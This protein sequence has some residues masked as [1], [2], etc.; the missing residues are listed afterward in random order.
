[1]TLTVAGG[2][3]GHYSMYEDNGTD[4]SRSAT[5]SVDYREHGGDHQLSISPARG[6][7]P[8]QV[9]Q[10]QWTVQFRDADAPH[11][12]LVDGHPARWTYDASTRTL[13]ATVPTQSVQRNTVVSYR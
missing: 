8:G 2:A 4:A 10:R 9:T 13:T 5:T 11:R 6:Q 12:V 7:F 1:V 3:D